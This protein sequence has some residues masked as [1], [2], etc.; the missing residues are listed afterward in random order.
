MW[1]RKNLTMPRKD[2]KLVRSVGGES[3]RM[4]ESFFGSTR[5]PAYDMEYP[6]TEHSCCD[7]QRLFGYVSDDPAKNGKRLSSHLLM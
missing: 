6:I 5:I 7:S 1:E 2:F 3:W 4:A